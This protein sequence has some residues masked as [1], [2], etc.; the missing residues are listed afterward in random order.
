MRYTLEPSYVLHARAWRESSLLLEIFSRTQGRVGLVARGARGKRSRWKNSLEPFRPL[1]MSWNQRSELGTLTEAE[2]IASP[3]PLMGEA[4]FCGLYANELMMLFNQRSDPHA[5]L[6]ENYH[7]LLTGLTT[8]SPPQPLLRRFE[9]GL[10]DS[11]GFGLQLEF[12]HDSNQPLNADQY[13][14]YVPGRGAI[15]V[16]AEAS[17]QR[18]VV[19]G[20]ALMALKS[21]NIEPRH[22]AELKA[23]M[24]TLIRF[25][26]GDRDIR[27]QS[28]FQDV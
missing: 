20:E 4:L 18:P 28:F 5:A 26:L 2:Q 14:E 11:A 24:R 22:Q 16:L 12:E 6:F 17:H 15:P 21:G 9:L 23:L 1:L 19:S 25:S 13:Y 7:D 10:L 27:S 3:P 8:G